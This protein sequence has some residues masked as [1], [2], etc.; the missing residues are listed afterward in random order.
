LNAPDLEAHVFAM[1][2]GG[3]EALLDALTTST[4]C[5]SKAMREYSGIA[6]PALRPFGK[7]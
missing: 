5:A 3:H 2:P 1:E 7:P 4:T 6:W